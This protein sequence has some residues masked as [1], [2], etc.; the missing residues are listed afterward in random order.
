MSDQYLRKVRVRLGGSVVINPSSQVLIR[1]EMKVGFY[2]SKGLSA[3]QNTAEIRI[4]NLAEGNR[5]AVGKELDTVEL[6]AG[7]MPPTGGGKFGLIFKGNIRD[8]QHVREGMDIITTITCGDGDAAIRRATISKSF[9]AGTKV[10]DVIDEVVKQLEAKGLTRG[11][12]KL[13]DELP[14]LKRPYAICG[15]CVRELNRLGRAF[16]F[17]WSSQNEKVEI[18]GGEKALSQMAMISPDTGMIGPPTIT[19]NGVIVTALLNPDIKPNHQVQIQSQFLDM[20][21]EGGTYRVGNVA[22]IGDNKDGDFLVE[23]EGEAIKG[24]KVDE[25]IKP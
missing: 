10:E 11:E 12:W 1:D 14:I 18:V 25:G 20:N 17:Y 4:W 7:Y 3:S 9:P 5:N 24:G 2:I 22:F 6:E 8:V 21:A 15:A 23:I 19:D 13:P 16:K